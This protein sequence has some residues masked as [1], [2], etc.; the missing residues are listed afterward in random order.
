MPSGKLLDAL[1]ASKGMFIFHVRGKKK[2]RE[3]KGREKERERA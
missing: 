3:S 1:H 2:R